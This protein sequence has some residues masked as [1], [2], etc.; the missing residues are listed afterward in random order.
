MVHTA[1]AEAFLLHCIQLLSKALRRNK[2]NVA[3]GPG[4]FLKIRMCSFNL[5]EEVEGIL[6]AV[7]ICSEDIA[8]NKTA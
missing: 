2:K 6:G 8:I 7:G 1:L 4:N 5:K 3:N